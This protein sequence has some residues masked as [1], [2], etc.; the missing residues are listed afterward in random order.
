MWCPRCKEKET[1]VIDSRVSGEFASI[2]RRRACLACQ[3]R[4]TTREYIEV[5]FPRVIKRDGGRR[6]FCVE[7]LR[8]GIAR[9]LEKRPVSTDQFEK[10]IA[11][12]KESICQR[13]EDEITSREIGAIIMDALRREDQ[14]AY[15][16]FASVYRSFENIESFREFING[17]QEEKS[18]QEG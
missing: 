6:Q 13:S 10:M 15:V 9:A 17:M 14:V 11:Q 3:Y 16:R 4:F 8:S 2:R 12:I 7:K 1:K 5:R 18:I